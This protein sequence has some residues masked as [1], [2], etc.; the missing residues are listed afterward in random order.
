VGK[1]DAFLVM[2]TRLSR[3]SRWRQG[4]DAMFRATTK[5]SG[6][7]LAARSTPGLP[8][9]PSEA[10]AGIFHESRTGSVFSVS[11]APCGAPTCG[12]PTWSGRIEA[13]VLAATYEATNTR[14]SARALPVAT[15]SRWP[16]A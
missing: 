1:V 10:L 6:G 3:P 12:F 16:A 7:K 14:Q 5:A 11:L 13:A 2:L 9:H 15:V 4:D 8:R